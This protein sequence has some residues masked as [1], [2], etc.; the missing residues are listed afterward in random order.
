MY[1]FLDIWTVF[2]VF[3]WSTCFKTSVSLTNPSPSRKIQL[4]D[5]SEFGQK[6]IFNFKLFVSKCPNYSRGRGPN[7]VWASKLFASIP[8]R[9]AMFIQALDNVKSLVGF[10]MAS[11]RYVV[12]LLAMLH[13]VY[14]A[15][16]NRRAGAQAN[17][18]L[19]SNVFRY[20]KICP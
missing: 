4:I 17:L 18:C 19:K 11:L 6:L 3:N 9:G 14:E 2:F 20:C 8:A 15:N 13:D 1:V 7:Q 12:R 5:W 16:W 10:F